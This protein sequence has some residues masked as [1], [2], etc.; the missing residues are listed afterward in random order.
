MPTRALRARRLLGPALALGLCCAAIAT[1]G[2]P[3]AVA[4]DPPA[5]AARTA[6]SAAVGVTDMVRLGDAVSERAHRLSTSG[7]AKS[8]RGEVEAGQLTE[9]YSARS[10]RDGGRFSVRLDVDRTQPLTL[11]FREIRPNDAWGETFGFR[12]LLDGT[13]FYVRDPATSD[14]GGGPYSSF[15][16]DSAD[17][18][19]IGDGEV[20]VTVEGSSSEPAY[21][22][23][24]WAYA[25][26]PGM[27][28]A[29]DMRVPDRMVF[30]LGQD[31]RGEAYFRSR[32]DYVRSAI[33]ESPEVGRGMA[34]LDYFP[35][36]S[37]AQMSANY[38][39]WLRL[40]REYGLPFGIES[41]SD[42]EGTPGGVPDGKGGTF[43]DLEYHQV[44]WSP[45]DQTGPDKDVFRD[46][47]LDD[48]LGEAYEPRYGLSVP[49]IWGSTPWLTWRNP[50]LNAYLEK[51]AD[52]SLDVIRPLVWDLQ[53]SGE[54]DRVLDFSTTMES[55]YWSKR[56]G[57]GVADQA[58]TDY[59]GGV[60][61]RDLYA[62]YNPSTVAAAKAEGVVL[63]PAD[64][65]SEAEKRW[66]FRNQSYPQQLFADVFYAGLPRQRIDAGAD[67]AVFPT[68][69]L[70][71][72][73]HAEVYSRMQE[74]YW[75]DVHPSIAQGIVHRARPGSEYIELDDYTK[76]GFWHLQKSREFGRI[77]NPNLENSV[78]GYAPDKTMLLR[79][80]YVNGSR[81]TSIY[82]WQG[83]DS[84]DAVATW[85]NPFVD[86]LHPWDVVRDAPP[87]GELTGRR[88]VSTTFTAGDLRLMSK[89]DVRTERTG[90]PTPLRLTV[91]DDTGRVV[92]MRHLSG[93]EIPASGWTSFDVPVVSLDKG[94]A[95]T[96]TVEQVGGGSAPAYAFGTTGGELALRVGLD[97][98]AERDRSLVIQWRRDAA[99]TIDNVGDDLGPGDT[100]AKVLLAAA[101]VALAKNR[102]VEAYRL[103]I[104]ADSLRF[105]VLYQVRGGGKGEL[106][107]FPV[108]VAPHS[109]VDIDVT[110]YSPGR[111]LDLSVRGYAAG[112]ATFTVSGFGEDPRVTVDGEPVPVDLAA[113][114]ANA[115]IDL[116]DTTAH[117]VRVTR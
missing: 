18:A 84:P 34:V 76:G 32:L 49:N 88:S 86:D 83:A 19:V 39:L 117:E 42:W 90:S 31:H 23:E 52:E 37:A 6:G 20:V 98:T 57:K 12:V 68:D 94:R 93:A 70:R 59:N 22:G 41:T 27:V 107:P 51:K 79:Q 44:L 26:L 102:Y 64:G 10:V 48:L 116:P 80:T 7:P 53:R 30:V 54:A 99:D 91:T 33:H 5:S 111:T 29:Q 87:D 14:P 55:T 73:V 75:D 65:L 15:F 56:G 46:Q 82:N 100:Q 45:Q 96:V 17:P 36:R 109:D 112:S 63:D 8:A 16:L 105:P 61:R 106:T 40:S 101:R 110:A 4:A 2:T 108:A 62:D 50:D 104:K 97:M 3:A 74:P 38:Q 58:Y 9:A 103:A 11:Q 81:Y 115:T 72:N 43:G 35:V 60:E 67:G 114:N 77:A 92:T 21:V 66:L 13:L 85:V 95:Y 71:H 78:S 24:I 28:N 69:G 89:V 47:R 25:D 113:G 1:G